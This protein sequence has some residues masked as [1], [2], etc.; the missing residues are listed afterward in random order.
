MTTAAKPQPS[1]VANALRFTAP[2][3][4]ALQQ[5]DEHIVVTGA[6]GWLGQ[7]LLEMLAGCV[8]RNRI[9]AF[10]SRA[11]DIP[12]R[13][14]TAIRSQPLPAL[15]HLPKNV[16]YRVFHFAF[17]T[18]DKTSGMTLEDYI[19]RNTAI[20]A[21]V[22]GFLAS[23]KLRGLC[24][25]SSGAAYNKDRSLSR[26]LGANPYGALK[27]EDEEFF[28]GRCKALGIPLTVP[29]IFNMSGPYINKWSAYALANLILM[30]LRKETLVI[31]AKHSVLRAYAYVGDIL[32]AVTYLGVEN[33]NAIFDVCTPDAVEIGELAARILQVLGSTS[34]VERDYHP[35]LPE[36]RYLGDS[37]VFLDA[38]GKAG[39]ELMDMDTQIRITADDLKRRLPHS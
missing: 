3:A 18:K 35:E 20:R 26:D 19:A 2:V 17:L 21:G 23:H 29:R 11:V 32:N 13:D 4:Q 39:V 7:A 8:D 38:C 31:K 14:E 9:H 36:D 33:Q 6:T 10:S 30:A 28:T 15:A 27:V 34:S 5:S 1:A 22:D 12:L 16:A 24:V 37:R 25:T